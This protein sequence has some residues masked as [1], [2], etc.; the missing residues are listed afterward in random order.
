MVVQVMIGLFMLTSGGTATSTA[1]AQGTA[2]DR[3]MYDN[4]EIF[5]QLSS[6][7]R[8]RLEARYGRKSSPPA[9]PAVLPEPVPF[10]GPLPPPANILVNDPA[11]DATL[12]DTQSETALVLGAGSNIV[13]AYNDSGSFIGGAKKFTG[14]SQSTDGGASFTDKGTLPTSA[15]GDAGDPVLARSASTGTIFL[16]TLAFDNDEKLM[17]FRSTDNGA[18]FLAPVNGAPGFVHGVDSQDKEWIAVDN[19]PGACQGNVYMFWRNFSS[20]GPRNGM[21]F[22]RSTDDGVTWGPSPGSLLAAFGQGAFVTV[23]TDHAVYVFWYDSSVSPRRISMRKSTD[24]GVSFGALVPVGN[25]VGTGSN[26]DLALNGGFRSNSFPH[27]AVNPVNGNIYVVYNDCS[28][29]PCGSSADHGNIFLRQSTDG[30]ATWSAAVQVNDD[31]T[32][33]DQF[34]PTIAVAPNGA[35]L[36]VPFYDRRADAANS[37]IGRWAAFAT[38]AGSTVTFQPNIVIADTTWPVVIGQ[39]P[40]VNTVYMGDFDMAACDNALCYTTWGDNRLAHL[41]HV[42]QPDVRF[43]KVPV[44]NSITGTMLINGVGQGSKTVKLKQGGVVVST[45]TTNGGG[46]YVFAP[47]SPGT[48]KIKIQGLSGAGTY[49]GNISVNG[50]GESGKKV[51]IS[52]DIGTTTTDGSGNFS[53]AAV[54]DG[55]HNVHVKS[56]DVP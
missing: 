22:T 5:N 10:G 55:N 43:A 35:S 54:P 40:V 13:S 47:V 2:W 23:G 24:C 4:D 21:T 32:T 7:A 50:V 27:A 1:F 11:A 30:G 15:D 36:F 29:T 56:V 26:G 9:A 53:K 51:K 14:F 6:G 45:T 34:M 42:H 38:I 20:S 52:K 19:F 28:S 31:G 49:S 18:S 25:L 16:S 41:T 33:R 8:L 39:D 44:P 37:L 12:Q 17:I 48:Y 46:Q 3:Q